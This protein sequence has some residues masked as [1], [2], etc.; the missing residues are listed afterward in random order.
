MKQRYTFALGLVVAVGL[1]ISSVP[2][3]ATTRST[4]SPKIPNVSVTWAT[5]TP[6]TIP[7]TRFDGEY[8]A[9]L[10]RVYFLGFRL[11]D[12]TT[13]GSVWYYDVATD[14]YVDTGRDMKVPVSNYQISAL[15]DSHGLGL[16]IFGGR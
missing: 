11:A 13:D 10:N 1:L 2:A 7:A 16:Y 14:T 9:S 6:L 3:S 12:N 5:G 15:T 4:A 8:V